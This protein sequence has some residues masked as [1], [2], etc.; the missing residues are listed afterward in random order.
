MSWMAGLDSDASGA[1]DSN[2]KLAGTG[3]PF[4]TSWRSA[5]IARMVPAE[6]AYTLT[7]SAPREAI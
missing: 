2:T 1:G 7:F 4:S 5:D 3:R 6:S